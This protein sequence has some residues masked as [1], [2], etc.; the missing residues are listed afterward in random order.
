MKDLGTSLIRTYVPI[1]VGAVAGYLTAKGVTLDPGALAGLT[2]FLT[3][4][5]NGLYY[6]VVRILE[7][8]W[9]QVG[10]LL[11]SPKEPVY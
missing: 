9:P 6:L 5:F 1:I 10:W 11:G 8:R 2:A 3:G 4:L 7:Q